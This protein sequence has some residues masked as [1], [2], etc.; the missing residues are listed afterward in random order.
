MLTART[1]GRPRCRPACASRAATP[2]PRRP[3]R[4]R[5]PQQE[6]EPL[7]VRAR[8]LRAGSRRPCS[9]GR[10]LLAGRALR[11]DLLQLAAR[12]RARRGRRSRSRE[13]RAVAG[14]L[15]RPLVDLPVPAVPH[16]G[17]P[18][19]R[20]PRWRPRRCGRA[21]A[22]TAVNRPIVD[23]LLARHP[24]LARPRPRA[25]QRLRPHRGRGPGG[26]RRR[27]SGSSTPAA[28]TAREQQVAA[29]LEALATLPAD[30][31]ALFVG[32]DESRV[33][34]EADRA[35]VSAA[36]CTSNRLVPLP[37][38]SATSA[39]P[40]RWCWSTGAGRR[41][42]RARCSSTCRP[43][44]PSSRS[45]RPAPPPAASSQET[46]AG[47]CRCP[48]NRWAD[49]ST[50]FVAAVRR[51]ASRRRPRRHRALRAVPPVRPSRVSTALRRAH[52]ARVAWP[53]CGHQ[54][55][56]APRAAAP[57]SVVPQR[58]DPAPRPRP[59]R[60][61]PPPRRPGGAAGRRR[62]AGAR[63]HLRLPGP[64]GR[65]GARPAGLLPSSRR[66]YWP[67]RPDADQAVAACSSPASPAA[68]GGHPG[69][70]PGRP[71]GTA[72]AVRL[73]RLARRGRLRGRHLLAGAAP[74]PDLR[75]RRPRPA[76]H[77]V[78]RLDAAHP[79]L[80]RRQG[81]RRALP[82]R[83]ADPGA[84]GAAHGGGGHDAT[85]PQAPGLCP[86]GRLRRRHRHH[87]ARIHHRLP[88]GDLAPGR[89]CAARRP[90]R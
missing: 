17:A 34:P 73:P 23:D 5:P 83:A 86:H 12:E 24:W 77:P 57:V 18:G 64:R 58:P 32:V 49:R 79:G 9:P 68:G 13:R 56:A 39:P 81:G 36:A 4:R 8:L 89:G 67:G 38:A 85:P 7:A 60:R 25:P 84:A 44:G 54:V 2:V 16:A 21:A 76:A 65:S 61:A 28:S 43:A 19:A 20:T 80:G 69:P 27:A 50:D 88:R 70:G 42:C 78:V 82:G 52:A 35:G 72:T 48:T 37:V 55:A 53:R 29:F 63:L 90:S 51:A 87:R 66:W 10:Q 30:V 1:T 74:A 33:R 75:G 14:R 71:G 26:P 3:A 46:G 15:P 45:R 40:T 62:R 47:T 41:P 6:A 59:A 22:V 31:K 11:R